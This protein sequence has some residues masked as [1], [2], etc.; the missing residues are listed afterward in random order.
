MKCQ[1]PVLSLSNVVYKINCKDCGLFYIGKTYRILS[2]RVQEHKNSEASA[3]TR[4]SLATNH[5][6]DYC[7]PQILGTDSGHTRL[8]VKET[9]NIKQYSAAKSINGNTGSFDLMLF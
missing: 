8:L 6:V 4:H 9:L 2:Q 1:I 5:T 3:L 7:N